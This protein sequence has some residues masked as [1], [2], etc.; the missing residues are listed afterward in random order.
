MFGN[1]YI[2]PTSKDKPTSEN[3]LT[4]LF[5]GKGIFL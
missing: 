4:L 3:K 5:N 1:V 2:K